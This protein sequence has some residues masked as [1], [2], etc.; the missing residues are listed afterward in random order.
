MKSKTV[1]KILFAILLCYSAIGNPI[2]LW[3]QATAGFTQVGSVPF[4]TNTFTDTTVTSGTVYQY[5][6][7][8]QNAAGVSVPSNIVT[9]PVIP[10]GTAPHSATLTWTAP[11]IGAQ[12]TTYLV[13]RMTVTIPNP[14]VV[15]STI[16]VAQNEPASTPARKPVFA[17]DKGGNLKVAAVR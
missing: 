12:P 1:G 15:S 3:A 13:E 5:E 17:A 6:V 4:G 10:S 2:R 14:P 7:L 9:A 16:T 8:S 11:A